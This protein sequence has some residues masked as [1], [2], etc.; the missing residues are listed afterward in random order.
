MQIEKQSLTTAQEYTDFVRAYATLLDEQL[1][2]WEERA[3][4]KESLH[5]VAHAMPALISLVNTVGHLRGQD[6]MFL[7]IRPQTDSQ[8]EFYGYEDLFEKR[9][10]H[11]IEIV[12]SSEEKEFY[13]ER[14]KQYFVSARSS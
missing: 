6:G 12:Q 13:I 2:I 14:L 5:E 11:L 7:H 8:K 9:L 3:K 10:N 4:N 1:A